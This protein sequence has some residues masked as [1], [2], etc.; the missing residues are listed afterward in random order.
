MRA[1]LTIAGLDAGR[2]EPDAP[3]VTGILCFERI[4]QEILGFLRDARRNACRV[5]ALA[6]SPEAIE[7]GSIWRLLHA[8]A[9]AAP[10]G[11]KRFPR[12]AAGALL[13][14]G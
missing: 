3:C 4:D 11:F 9:S 6:A 14:S 7:K 5:L 2:L 12:I 1:G 8:G 10:I 13:T